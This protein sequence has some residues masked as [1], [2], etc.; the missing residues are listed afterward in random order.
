MHDIDLFSTILFWIVQYQKLYLIIQI[1]DMAIFWKP[2]RRLE[3]MRSTE[4]GIIAKRPS[5]SCARPLCGTYGDLPQKPLVFALFKNV[6]LSQGFS[7]NWRFFVSKCFCKRNYKHSFTILEA[8][9]CFQAERCFSHICVKN[10]FA[11]F[12]ENK[13]IY[14]HICESKI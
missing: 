5:S 13:I 2:V 11:Y 9:C 6:L 10:V 8:R 12:A 3:M 7:F 1:E 14:F 4:L